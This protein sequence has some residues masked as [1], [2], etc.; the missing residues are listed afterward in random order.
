MILVNC[1]LEYDTYA[2]IYSFFLCRETKKETKKIQAKKILP[3]HKAGA[4]RFF[5]GP[6]HRNKPTYII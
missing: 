4:S 3:P 6:T 2:L 5:G 1:Y